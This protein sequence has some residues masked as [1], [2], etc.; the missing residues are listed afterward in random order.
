L[1]YSVVN[2]RRSWLYCSGHEEGN[3]VLVSGGSYSFAVSFGR[4]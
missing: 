3:V 4:G 2:L 1:W